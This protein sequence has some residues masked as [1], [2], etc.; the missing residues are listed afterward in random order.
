MNNSLWKLCRVLANKNRLRILRQLK[1]DTEACVSDIAIEHS[2]TRPSASKHIRFLSE[3]G[4]IET[5]PSGKWLLCRACKPAKDHPLYDL[6]KILSK[7]LSSSEKQIDEIYRSATAFTHERRCCI[8]RLLRDRSM[9]LNELV[10]A[11]NIS[12][13]ALNRHLGKLILRGLVAET[14]ETYR[15]KQP[16]DPLLKALLELLLHS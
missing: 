16:S 11:S 8:I 2:L 9:P 15:F 12:A 4:F 10:E 1:S 3:Y 6:Q 14:N 7:K 5:R 13:I